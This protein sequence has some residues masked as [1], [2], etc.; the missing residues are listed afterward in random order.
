MHALKEKTLRYN[1]KAVHVPD[2]KHVGPGGEAYDNEVEVDFYGP[3]VNGGQGRAL[4]CPPSCAPSWC[5]V[6]DKA[7]E[8]EGMV[9]AARACLDDDETH[10]ITSEQ[11]QLAASV[12]V[13]CRGLVQLIR[14]G[15]PKQKGGFKDGLKPFFAN[16]EELYKIDEVPFLHG[17]M[18]IPSKLRARILEILHQAHQGVSGMR[19]K[20][21]ESFW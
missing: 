7:L 17:R 4:P 8:E 6:G 20:A 12:D 16:R 10:E 11:V 19:A 3:R 14:T 2:K 1:F 13:T 9:T 5:E 15:F 18:L 21:R